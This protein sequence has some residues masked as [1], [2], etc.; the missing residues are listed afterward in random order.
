MFVNNVIDLLSHLT[1]TVRKK[2]VL[3]SFLQ[4]RI[5]VY[6]WITDEVV[7]DGKEWV[8]E[9]L[10]ASLTHIHDRESDET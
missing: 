5:I 3:N 4:F 9:R 8:S 10:V 7:S 2:F 6:L 1:I